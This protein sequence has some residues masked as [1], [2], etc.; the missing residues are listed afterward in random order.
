M[1]KQGERESGEG[2]GR[3]VGFQIVSAFCVDKT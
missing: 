3:E 2:H 1:V